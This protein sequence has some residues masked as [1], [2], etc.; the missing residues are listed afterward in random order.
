MIFKQ[1]NS[2]VDKTRKT[3]ALFNKDWKT[4]KTNWQ[5]ASGISGKI[6]S[7]F[8]SSS[9]N[10][11]VISNEKVQILRNWNNAVTHGCTNQETFNRIIANADDNTK[12]YFAGLNKG[13]GSIDG[14]KNAQSVT[15]Q[16][17]IGLTI[18]QTALNAVIGMGIGLFINL[19]VQGVKKLIH[20][21]E[22]AIEKAGE[23]RKKYEDFKNTNASNVNILNGL[24][25]EFKELSKGVSQY[26]DNV[27]LTT[28]QYERYKEIIQQIVGISPSLAEGYDTENGYIVD[29]NSLLERAI[30]LQEQEYRNELREITNLDNLKTSMS[31]YIA[32]YKK[33]FDGGFITND[34]SATSTKAY[35]N[36]K[37]A[38][39][40][41]FNTDN[42][43]NFSSEDMI[44][45]IM[46]SIDVKDIE[47]EMAKYYNK[48]GYFQD[49]DFWNNYAD[50]I[51]QNIQA[52]TNSLNAYDVGLD[53]TIFDQNIEKADSA[54][55]SYLDMKDAISMANESIQRDLGYIAEYAD[56]YSNLSTEQQKFVNDFLKGFNISDIMSAS[57]NPFDQGWKFDENKMASVK[58]QITKFV[59]AL[60][61]DET[62]KT[63]LA[64]LYAIPTDEQSISEF[65]E[66][67]K[68]AFGIIDAYCKKNGIEM[69]VA[70]T[71]SKKA[72]NDLEAQYQRAVDFAKNK[73]DGYDPTKFFNQHSINTQE[74]I[75]NWQKIAQGANSAAEA[76][77][78]YLQNF[79]FSL[80]YTDILSQI[81]S[82]SSALDQLDQIYTDIYDK[83]D[84]DWSS[85]LN[86]NDFTEAFGEMGESYDN[87]I[88]TVSEAPEDL[89][90]CQS[91][92][93]DLLTSYL[94][95]AED[96]DGYSIMSNLTEETKQA[97]I[98]MLSQMGVANALE[99]VE[100]QLAK[101]T[102][103]LTDAQ[104]EQAAI[105]EQLS[106]KAETLA[107][108]TSLD[109]LEST[110]LERASYAEIQALIDEANT[111]G[112]TSDALV[113]FKLNKMDIDN[114]PI[115]TSADIDNL[116][117]MAQAAGVATKSVGQ[118]AA[119]KAA[120]DKAVKDMENGVA[121]ASYKVSGI[122]AQMQKAAE[123][124]QNDVINFKPTVTYGG[125]SSYKSAIE[126]ATG[127]VE[128]EFSELM[129]FF[130][131]RIAILDD[132]LDLLSAGLENVAGAFAKN[133]IID[134]QLSINKEK[135][136]NYSDALAMYTEKAEELLSTIP[137][138]IADK[139]KNG[140]VSLTE[141]VGAGNEAVVEAIEDYES[142]ADKISDC[143]QQLTSLK[144]TIAQLELD[145]F[146]NI[147]Q[148]FADQFDLRDSAIGNIDKQIALL[149]EMGELVGASYYEAQKSL[150]EKQLET[151]TDEK[152]AL[153]G[154]LEEALS[155]GNIQSGSEQWLE[156]VNSLSDVEGKILDCKTAVEKYDNALLQLD[157]D[158]FDR[159][160]EA[161]ANVQTELSHLVDLFDDIDVADDSTGE[162]TA[163]ALAKLGLLAQ[164]YEAAQ[165]SVSDY[166]KAITELKQDYA[167]GNYSATE[168]AEKLA[169]LKDGQW[170]AVKATEAAKE[171][172]VELNEARIDEII[173][174][175]EKEKDAYKELVD[176]QID[177]LD[178]EKELHDYKKSIQ[179]KTK[180]VTDLERQIAALENDTSAA[181]I[182]KRKKLAAELAEAQ[183]ALE[184]AEYE[185]SIEAQKEAINQQY[186]DFAAEKDAEIEA[187]EATLSDI[188]KLIADSLDA[189]KQNAALV[190]EQIT[191]AAKE[192][193]ITV[194]E[195]V[196]SPWK[197][198]EG[199]IA[200]YGETLSSSTSAFVGNLGAIKTETENL[201]TQADNASHSYAS[202]FSQKSDDLVTQLTTAYTSTENLYKMAKSLSDA[203]KTA[204]ESGYNV[205]T[206][207]KSLD[208]AGE[209]IETASKIDNGDY[210]G[211]SNN[212]NDDD[213]KNSLTKKKWYVVDKNG[214]VLSSGYSSN[215]EASSKIG[216]TKG[217]TDIKQYTDE[218]AAK[219]KP[220][221]CKILDKNGTTIET[222]SSYEEGSK[223]V[224]ELN[225]K[226]HGGYTL[227]QYAS[228]TRYTKGELLI[229][230]EEGYE[231]GLP[232]LSSGNYAL[233]PEGSQILT[234][235]QTDNLFEW[236]KMNPVSIIPDLALPAISDV[237]NRNVNQPVT[238]QNNITFTGAV[239]DANSFARDIAKIA[240]KQVEKSWKK[241]TDSLKY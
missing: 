233:M 109:T 106:Q 73:F 138:D 103:Y 204:L 23:L 30:E 180:T 33:A 45:Q 181:G 149:E 44:R 234:K 66:Q 14:L 124:A 86:N 97:T 200:G 98:A 62:T 2:S 105:C 91:A 64:N 78:E 77:K 94:Y 1:I 8:T 65:I 113:S 119:L 140:A 11:S 133:S 100:Y 182:A 129:D 146:N 42:R 191:N 218:E 56:G 5:N 104:A 63:A 188:E 213:K 179:E 132:S 13:K 217:G 186:E 155:S 123:E 240:D 21:N 241:A 59:E 26:G 115:N 60:S 196:V 237:A 116:L 118:L 214:N 79:K 15:T 51:A 141:F 22:E 35:T 58:S 222:Y 3:L 227:K 28:K 173:E 48:Y 18:A 74:E 175:I 221:V 136:S 151:L 29:K 209:N 6:G 68:N 130:E 107:D 152:N 190:G 162:W 143:N 7:I 17:T 223:R 41:I 159:Q 46:V 202:I 110:D 54:A 49:Q 147:A 81:Q 39:Y 101:N 165:I 9:A 189:V 34:M 40:A 32:E 93:D 205:S 145:K 150:A 170:E 10:T 53:N 24:E 72:I 92:F 198:G 126:K 87:F 216:S 232:K 156:M 125:G 12:M 185:H 177:A 208:S 211:T 50:I 229:K 161:I 220:P 57:N 167:D 192:H 238:I 19:V 83:E 169:E 144:Q 80:P 70:I 128:S 154:A 134:S 168:Y 99:V 108:K 90:K 210:S 117:S 164:Q 206:L 36:L 201:Q 174:G 135:I 183:E 178:A 160:Q 37:N 20:A 76:E 75:D 228:G 61:Q 95:S 226:G 88:K 236:A 111:L 114:T 137:A 67:F 52:I 239:N 96:S 197:N 16:S 38:I 184:E 55:Q 127:S 85:I 89:D 171:A 158:T 199:A 4:Y 172:I 153:A 131:R 225:D 69:P 25:N 43:D 120:Y 27:S 207:T 163:D 235:A 212:N 84:F 219:H 230:D 142:W 112:I 122:A 157:W 31:G 195:S 224:K 187:L 194:S 82:L 121:G 231:L 193:G 148:D 166:D 47:T 139:V 102:G 215:G 176:A 203:Y 71:N